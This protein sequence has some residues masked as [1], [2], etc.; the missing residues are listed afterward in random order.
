ML[1]ILA[2][3]GENNPPSRT[4]SSGEGHRPHEEIEQDMFTEWNP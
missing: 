1:C 4:S 2:A 3:G